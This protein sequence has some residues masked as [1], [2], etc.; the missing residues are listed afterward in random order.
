MQR[1]F[2]KGIVSGMLLFLLLLPALSFASL[3]SEKPHGSD[4]VK[5]KK[6]NPG[7][8]VFGHIGDSH[9]W[10]LL[11][12][13]HT[14][15]SIPLPVI[16][17]SRLR[18]EF[19][20]FMSSKFHHGHNSY[21]GF[22]LETEGELAG[23]IIEVGADGVTRVEGP[24]PLDFSMKKNVVAIFFSLLLMVW[25]FIGIARTYR[26]NPN[27]APRGIQNLIEAIILFIRDDVA[28]PALG[29][30]YL[31]FTPF[32][33]SVFFFIWI[34]N[35][36][37][38]IPIFP[39]GANVTGNIAVTM[40]LAI[41]TFLVINLNGNKHYWKHIV[42]APGIP[43]FLKIPVPIMPVVEFFGIFIKPFVL[44]VRL[45][46]NILAGH[47]VIMVLLSLI[48]IFGSV[49]IYMGYGISVV[50]LLLVIFM[51]FLEL[52]VAAIQA[53]VFTMLSAIFIGM[54]TAEHH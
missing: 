31:K 12:V 49:N 22:K 28:K 48:F 37:G 6:F 51:T 36:L 24:L 29:H 3:G 8:F 26:R 1:Y 4:E 10:H 45:F 19:F 54:A 13:G 42:N 50:S 41:F 34:N 32:L 25:L 52:L 38:L 53:Y 11:T 2:I 40:A 23:K 33:L 27:Q 16:L 21:K 47:I 44:M 17:Y 43:V 39:A 35:L 46:A 20:I 14:H 9:E 5:Q 15:I 30:N 7:E 18:G